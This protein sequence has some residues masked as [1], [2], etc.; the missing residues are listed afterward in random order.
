[1]SQ[2]AFADLRG[3]SRKQ[4]TVWK[5][6]GYLT[7]TGNLVEVEPSCAALD[8]RPERYRGGRTKGGLPPEGRP[9][10]AAQV[11]RKE[12][13]LADKHE[14]IAGKLGGT[15]IDGLEVKA[16]WARAMNAVRNAVLGIPTRAKPVLN[17]DD[18][19]FEALTKIVR[20]VL[21]EAARI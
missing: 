6:K 8:G 5:A 12:K 18:Q 15:L 9:S 21:N 1:M 7:M 2:A 13:A 17:L 20:A 14:L 11:L 10:L 3:V 4:V 16:G 19:Q